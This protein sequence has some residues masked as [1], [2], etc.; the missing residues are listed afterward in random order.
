MQSLRAAYRRVENV[1]GVDGSLP[2]L[3]ISEHQVNPVTDTLGHVV[4]LQG[5]P[6]EEGE[7]ARVVTGP[8]RE[9]DVV[10]PFSTLTH[11]EIK[12]Y[13]TPPTSV[14]F[15][16]KACFIWP[17][18]WVLRVHRNSREHHGQEKERQ[19]GQ[20]R[21]CSSMHSPRSKAPRSVPSY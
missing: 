20:Q 1:G 7:E 21:H 15:S 19:R 16:P 3:L 8:G 13:K 9:A 5:L 18:E 10:N 6:V 12:T 4:R 14:F 17:T 11:T 2:F